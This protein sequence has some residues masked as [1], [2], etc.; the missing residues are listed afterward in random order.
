M[1]GTNRDPLVPSSTLRLTPKGS[2]FW[3][4]AHPTQHA[5]RRRPATSI[6]YAAPVRMYIDESGDPGTKLDRK[7]TSPHF[8]VAG[9]LVKDELDLARCT[10]GLNEFASIALRKRS[11]FKFNRCDNT[12]RTQYLQAASRLPWQY[13]AIVLNKSKLRGPGFQFKDTVY[14]YTVRLL[15]SNAEPYLNEATLIFDACGSR[16]FRDTMSPYCKSKAEGVKRVLAQQSHSDPMLQLAD[17]VAGA[18]ARSYKPDLAESGTFRAIIR[19]REHGVQ[20]WPA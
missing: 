10:R 6:R 17:M 4:S 20:F 11:E 1:A 7:G 19:G 12:L 2:C 3:A 14:K 18:V 13:L 8:V 9:V 15:L 16:D 5:A